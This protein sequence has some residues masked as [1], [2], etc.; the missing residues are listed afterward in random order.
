MFRWLSNV[1]GPLNVP[2]KGPLVV[3]I[4]Q[5]IHTRHTGTHAQEE[6]LVYTRLTKIRVN[7]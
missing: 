3:D 7:D 4:E 1:S 5:K 2:L 6:D